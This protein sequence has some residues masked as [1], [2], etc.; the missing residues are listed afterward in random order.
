MRRLP[1]LPAGSTSSRRHR[2]PRQPTRCSSRPLQG[3]SFRI[4]RVAIQVGCVSPRPPF[5]GSLASRS[6]SARR[7]PWPLFRLR[8]LVTRTNQNVAA[9]HVTAQNPWPRCS[10]AASSL[11]S[12]GSIPQRRQVP[13]TYAAA[14]NSSVLSETTQAASPR[15]WQREKPHDRLPSVSRRTASGNSSQSSTANH[16]AALRIGRS[17]PNFS[18]RVLAPDFSRVLRPSVRAR[19]GPAHEQVPLV[20]L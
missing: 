12:P 13:L 6:G 5:R 2:A 4:V 7:T 18:L 15:S 9:R 14:P 19:A 1:L 10:C 16:L 3:N 17:L 8:P 11:A 20:V